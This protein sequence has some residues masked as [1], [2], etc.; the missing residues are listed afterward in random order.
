MT[1]LILGVLLAVP[2][3]DTDAL[4]KQFDSVRN[5][6]ESFVVRVSIRNFENGKQDEQ[7]L[8]DVYQK[9]AEKTYVEFLSP[10]EKGRHLLMLGDDM[11]IYLPDTS[12]PIRI[13][14]LERLSG[15][16]SNGDVA[17][18]SYR[19]DYEAVFLRTEPVDG[20]DCHLLELTARR[21]G[22][23]YR[24]IH[25]WLRA[26]DGRPVKADFFVASG[27]Q[28]KSATY[29]KYQETGGRVLLRQ[30]TIYDQVRKGSRS[31]MEYLDFTPRAL[32]DRIFH[33]GR[34]ERY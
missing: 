6:W 13:T 27:K 9:G 26:R 19:L 8:F 22:S 30:I 2:A 24:K 21:K 18:T 15:N 10:R 34:S 11:W 31:V 14:P 3:P 23:T 7:H 33:Q 12:R 20:T 16:A 17:R 1:G 5:G 28:L 4:M 29:D 32:P 25:L